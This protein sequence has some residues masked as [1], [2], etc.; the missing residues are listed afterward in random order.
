[1]AN[2]NPVQSQQPD[3]ALLH[4]ILDSPR[5]M[6]IF[7]LDSHYRYTAFSQTHRAT[8]KA[9][10]DVDIALGINMLDCIGKPDDRARA[11][12]NFDRALAGEHFIQ[13]EEYGKPDS[14]RRCYENRYGPLVD[15]QQQIIGLTVFVTDVSAQI[16]AEG[17]LRERDQLLASVAAASRVLLTEIDE[18]RAIP[19]AFALIGQSTGVDRIYLFE[20]H[21]HP[22][23]G[24]PSLSQRF[25]WCRDGISHQLDNEELINIPIEPYRDWIDRFEQGQPVAGH[26]AD[27]SGQQRAILEAQDIRSILMLPI[28]VNGAFWGFV[29]IDN[30]SREQ[31]WSP[32]QRDVLQTLA[33]DLGNVIERLR[34]EARIEFLAHHDQVTGLPNR[35][36]LRDRLQQAL[37]QAQRLNKLAALLFLDLDRFKSVNDSLGHQVGD[38]LLKTVAQRLQQCVRHVDTVSRQGGD[39]FL[40]ILTN[41][42]SVGDVGRITEKILDQIG[43]PFEIDGRTIL[44]SFSIGISIYPN[45]GDN[46]SS[47]IQHADTALYHAKQAG[48]NTYRFFTDAMNVKVRE[49]VQMEDA[50]RRALSGQQ[51]H[52]H[53]QPQIDLTTR[54]VDGLEA[55]L[56]WDGDGA[57]PI[58]PDRFIPIAEASGLII[59]IGQW[60][61]DEVCRQIRVWLDAGLPAIRIAINLSALQFQRGN[62]VETVQAALDKHRVAPEWLELELTESILIQDE[63]NVL[64]TVR[65]LKELGV[66]LTI[67]D[68]GTGYSSLAY[69]KRFAVD[70]LKID[71]SF[72]RDLDS[73]TDDATIVQAIIQM[74][75]SLKL[76]IVAEGVETEQQLAF[77]GEHGC[78]QVQGYY[79]ARPLPASECERWLLNPAQR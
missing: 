39:E 12:A 47:L 67:D 52:L 46:F 40:V 70:K 45:D 17:A 23:D 76:R 20:R 11:Q 1:M 44:T 29:G 58:S 27:F 2:N 25:E 56:R 65:A 6:V 61:L 28:A 7:A 75:R 22:D 49:R 33:S 74:G 66:T 14:Q 8:M 38:A 30:C 43:Q 79:F 48:R 73:D 24:P 41:V 63:D 62:L 68:F 21:D 9:I 4:A 50:L 13:R 78:D 10:W 36:L 42:D 18:T 60:V 51:F 32:L 34:A 77:L 69:L 26:V 35:V 19:R 31:T 72:I 16:E 53:Y 57:E 64:A 55:L 5:G 54:R 15:E 59:P 37:A 3:R 71:K